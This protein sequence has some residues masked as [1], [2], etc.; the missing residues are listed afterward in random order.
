MASGAAFAVSVSMAGRLKLTAAA[1]IASAPSATGHLS[2]RRGLPGSA[3]ETYIKDVSAS[4]LGLAGG[5][6]GGSSH[7]LFPAGTRD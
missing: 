7:G 5:C 2:R 1:S 4:C 3:C 6:E